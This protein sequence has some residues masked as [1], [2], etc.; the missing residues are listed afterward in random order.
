MEINPIPSIPE[1]IDLYKTIALG[2]HGIQL[3]E[4]TAIGKYPSKCVSTL[5]EINKIVNRK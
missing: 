2:V 3:S 5:T 4:E 1:V